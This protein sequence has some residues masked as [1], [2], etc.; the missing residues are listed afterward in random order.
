[1]RTFC[2]SENIFTLFGS[3]Q[4]WSKHFSGRSP[5]IPTV[6]LIPAPQQPPFCLYFILL[7]IIFVIPTKN[8]IQKH[9]W[10]VYFVHK[11]SIHVDAV[12]A[13]LL[14]VRCCCL[15]MCQFCWCGWCAEMLML[16]KCWC[17]N[18]A[19][20]LMLLMLRER[21]CCWYAG[22]ADSLICTADAL[23]L[24]MGCCFRCADAAERQFCWCA[25][26]TESASGSPRRPFD[27]I[28]L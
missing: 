16:L 6:L 5:N 9:C 7:F 13:M 19:D 12:D 4:K 17:T 3:K 25:D 1:M 20:A 23:L 21:W 11:G 8:V 27:S 22:I 28:Q 2:W 24:L 18:A 26:A 15:L 14:I 10:H